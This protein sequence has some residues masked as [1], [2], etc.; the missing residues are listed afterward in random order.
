MLAAHLAAQHRD[1]ADVFVV[2]DYLYPVESETKHRQASDVSVAFGCPEVKHDIYPQVVF[3]VLSPGWRYTDMQAKFTFYE[4]HGAE[5]YYILYPEFPAH[6]EG[7]L[8][9]EGKLVRVEEIDGFVSPRL[10]LRFSLDR[11]Q[12]GVFDRNG[13]QMRTMEELALE[14]DQRERT[15]EK[16]AAKLRELGVDPDTL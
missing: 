1:D 10:G 15:A 3:D 13:R 14:N 12:L 6:A 9:G 4:K 11:G 7:Y 5:E 2:G 16:L 8:R